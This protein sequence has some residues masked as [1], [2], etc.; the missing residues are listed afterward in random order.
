[1]IDSITYRPPQAEDLAALFPRARRVV[2]ISTVD[3]YGEDIGGGP[4]KF[5]G[6]SFLTSPRGEI[7]ARVSGE[8][9]VILHAT[10]DTSINREMR[11][12][13]GFF[14]DRRPDAYGALVA[15]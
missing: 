14:R 4:A 13:W 1:V 9:D 12:E 6:R 7:M 5:Y 8:K 11:E 2:L 3:V 15:P 10:I